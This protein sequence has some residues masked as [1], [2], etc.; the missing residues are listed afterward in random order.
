MQPHIILLQM[1]NTSFFRFP[2]TYNEEVSVP[3]QVAVVSVI[4]GLINSVAFT[5]SSGERQIWR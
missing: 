4:I 3:L 2:F 5:E 1:E